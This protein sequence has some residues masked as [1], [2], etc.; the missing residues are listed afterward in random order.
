M[1]NHKSAS[2]SLPV[3]DRGYRG[4]LPYD[5]KDPDAKFEPIQPTQPPPGAPNVLIVL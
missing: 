2:V 1:E 5:A 4:F 3:P